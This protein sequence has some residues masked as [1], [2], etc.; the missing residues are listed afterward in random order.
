VVVDLF[1]KNQDKIDKGF[2]DKIEHIKRQNSGLK[3]CITQLESE[4][5]ALNL[6]LDET[7]EALNDIHVRLA[8]TENMSKSA[9]AKANHNEQYSRKFNVKIYGIPESNGEDRLESVNEALK[10]IG[11]EIQEST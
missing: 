11:A 8:E 5:C 9:L 4:K 7:N 1:K 2:N 3:N 10:D 6:E